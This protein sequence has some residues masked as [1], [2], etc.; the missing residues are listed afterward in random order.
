MGQWLQ[1]NWTPVQPKK[2]LDLVLDMTQFKHYSLSIKIPTF[3]GLTNL[4]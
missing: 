3:D 4:A 2:L 1:T